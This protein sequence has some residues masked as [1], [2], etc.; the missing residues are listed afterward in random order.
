MWEEGE[1]Q[2]AMRKQHE[3]NLRRDNDAYYEK[4]RLENSKWNNKFVSSVSSGRGLFFIIAVFG[5]G[6]LIKEYGGIILSIVIT[7]GLLVVTFI[8]IKKA[9]NRSSNQPGMGF[10]GRNKETLPN[11]DAYEGDYVNGYWHGKGTLILAS[12]NVYEGDFVENICQGKGKLVFANGDTYEGDFVQG[13][14]HGKGKITWAEGSVYEG[15]LVENKRQGK[16]KHTWTNGDIYEGD[17][18]NDNFHGKGKIILADGTI[19]EG[20][21]KD[22]DFVE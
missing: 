8:I 10:T 11:G 3:E 12:G 15:D 20:T 1:F 7:V 16:G 4:K 19:K 18:V 21:F 6:F 5:I 2:N 22:G 9:K 14:R 13:K 17:F